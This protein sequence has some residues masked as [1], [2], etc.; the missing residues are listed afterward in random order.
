V[1]IGFSAGTG[2][3]DFYDVAVPLRIGEEIFAMSCDG[4]V[5]NINQK[6]MASFG[7]QMIVT[8]NEIERLA[9]R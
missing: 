7:K 9:G 1:W 8:R 4:L 3:R 6:A 5:E 2:G